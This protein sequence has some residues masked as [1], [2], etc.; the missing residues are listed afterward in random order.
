M[1]SSC[2]NPSCSEEFRYLHQGKLFILTHARNEKIIS[3]RLDFA[4]HVD[5]LHY[6]W[7]CDRCAPTFEV[8]LDSEDRVKIRARYDFS[9]LAVAV[10]AFIGL[11]LTPAMGLAC[12][13]CELV[14]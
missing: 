3:K 14:A 8:V 9:G 4:G 7:L 11:Q 13:L 12:N 10:A 1:L 2:A 5:H 6:A